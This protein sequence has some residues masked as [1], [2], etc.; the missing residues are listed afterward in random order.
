MNSHC[1]VIVYLIILVSH[2]G[3][4]EAIDYIFLYIMEFLEPSSAYTKDALVIIHGKSE[5]FNDI[6]PIPKKVKVLGIILNEKNMKAFPLRSGI[7]Q[8]YPPLPFLFNR[9]LDIL[10][11]ALGRKQKYKT[12]KLSYI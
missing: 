11:R 2:C 9:V 3:F 10:A 4:C 5:Q 1:T 8:G 7:K 6:F 12:S